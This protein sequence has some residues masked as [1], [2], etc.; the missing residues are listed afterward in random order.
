MGRVDR[1]YWKIIQNHCQLENPPQ[2]IFFPPIGPWLMFLSLDYQSY[3]A[4]NVQPVAGFFEV[5]NH[6][7]YTI[8]QGTRNHRGLQSQQYLA[9]F[10]LASH[11]PES[12]YRSYLLPAHTSYNYLP[13]DLQG[14]RPASFCSGTR[15]IVRGFA[16]VWGRKRRSLGHRGVLARLL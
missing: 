3:L 2:N 4:S 1:I 13:I 9:T 6:R 15:G 14:C 10:S 8:P 7:G 12:I 5:V 16:G 11:I